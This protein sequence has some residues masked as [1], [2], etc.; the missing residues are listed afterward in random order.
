VLDIL[1]E[2]SEYNLALIPRGKT[3]IADALYTSDL[4]FKIS[5]FPNKKYE[6][7]VKHSPIVPDNIKY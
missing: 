4:V 1:E 7:E 5:F 6:V 3:Q 2:L